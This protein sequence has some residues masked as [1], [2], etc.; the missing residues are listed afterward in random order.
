MALRN[1]LRKAP[2]IKASVRR[3]QLI[4]T[5]G[6]GSVLP[7]ESES[8]M[9]AGLEHWNTRTCDE[10]EEP[11]LRR[12]LGVNQLLTPPG[13]ETGGMVPMVRFPEWVSCPKCNR[14]D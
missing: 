5:Y 14:L 13:G 8:F 3:A 2:A 9:I 4:T 11:R 10:I 7:V 12:L 6:V 1:K